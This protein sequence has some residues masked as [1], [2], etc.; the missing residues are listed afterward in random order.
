MKVAAASSAFGFAQNEARQASLTSVC[1]RIVSRRSMA[2]SSVKRLRNGVH[3]CGRGGLVFIQILAAVER[4]SNLEVVGNVFCA[5]MDQP[6][7]MQQ[8]FEVLAL[9]L[10]AIQ[11]ILE[12]EL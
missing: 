10:D 3:T 2:R 7:H 4:D 8:F 1:S 5:L 11:K 9:D 6:F 12:R